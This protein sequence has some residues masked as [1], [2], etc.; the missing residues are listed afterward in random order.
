MQKEIDVNSFEGEIEDLVIGEKPVSLWN[1][2]D[3]YENNHGA[4]ERD[5]LVNLQPST[6]FR[7]NG[8]GYAIL[9]A[10]S[11]GFRTRSD[12]QLAFK[13]FATEGLLFL[14]GQ[15]K[16]FIALELRNGKVLYQVS[17]FSNLIKLNLNAY[18]SITWAIK[19]KF[20]T[21]RKPTTMVNGM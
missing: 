5:K 3:G 2:N 12:I 14:A 16:T 20:G 11:Y 9:N 19:L 10:R 8:N 18:L 4:I 7:F 17:I 1:F 21:L 15:D 6:G 13:T